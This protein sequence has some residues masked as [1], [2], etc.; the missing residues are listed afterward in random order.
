MRATVPSSTPAII[1]QSASTILAKALSLPVSE[2]PSVRADVFA[3]FVQTHRRT[4]G[5]LTDATSAFG[6]VPSDREPRTSSD[7]SAAGEAA[8]DEY[9]NSLVENLV[10][11]W[12]VSVVLEEKWPANALKIQQKAFQ[13]AVDLSGSD[14][15]GR[16][17]IRR[18]MLDAVRAVNQDSTPIWKRSFVAYDVESDVLVILSRNSALI[19]W[20]SAILSY[21]IKHGSLTLSFVEE[22]FRMAKDFNTN[23]VA[24]AL[25]SVLTPSLRDKIPS[26]GENC[27]LRF[28]PVDHRS[29]VNVFSS[30][31][32]RFVSHDALCNE[33]FRR[34]AA[35]YGDDGI[36]IDELSQ[37]SFS[38]ALLKAYKQFSFNQSGTSHSVKG[39]DP[40]T[41]VKDRFKSTIPDLEYQSMR[42]MIGN[43]SEWGN[44]TSLWQ[45]DLAQDG[46]PARFKR[47]IKPPAQDR[48]GSA[49]WFLLL[50][51][52]LEVARA[53]AESQA[54]ILIMPIS[55]FDI[56]E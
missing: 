38:T 54:R 41:S 10:D 18:C 51:E 30:T 37:E 9:M 14:N 19:E 16:K 2:K 34:L 11:S 24:S 12:H 31:D 28:G 29:Q 52:L 7:L 43:R 23:P 48:K 4:H 3:L 44:C 15:P 25:K 49:G 32:E 53:L 27:V 40:A 22:F 5:I 21:D 26:T 55:D 13:L 35:T 47:M 1:I 45:I 46:N 6:F 56:Y 50:L 8:S 42:V 36:V 17:L 39:I 33:M 20:L